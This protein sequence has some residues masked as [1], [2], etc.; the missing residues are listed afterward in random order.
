MGSGRRGGG[1]AGV[2]PACAHGS[3]LASVRERTPP[4]RPLAAVPRPSTRRGTPPRAAPDRQPGRRTPWPA[5]AGAAAPAA[6]AV[7][8]GAAARAACSGRLMFLLSSATRVAASWA[9]RLPGDLC[10]RRP[11]PCTAPLDSVQLV[12]RGGGRPSCLRPGPARWPAAWRLARRRAGGGHAFGQA[13]A[14]F[15][16]VAALRHHASGVASPAGTALRL[17]ARW[18]RPAR[19]RPCSRLTL[20]PM[21]ASGLARSIATSIWSSETLAGLLAAAILPAVSPACTVTCLPSPA[22]RGCRQA[23][24]SRAARVAGAAAAGGAA[25]GGAL[26]RD[27]RGHAAR[28]GRGAATV[29]RRDLRS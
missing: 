10:L 26:G 25:A 8:P 18:A 24:Q 17:L 7:A 13:A 28:R 6:G 21:K 29:R 4:Q 16:E 19:R 9:A 3:A 1:V 11:R 5:V 23:P 15:V 14:E 2:G 22:C 27:R 20:P 12:G